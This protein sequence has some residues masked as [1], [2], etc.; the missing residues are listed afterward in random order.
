MTTEEIEELKKALGHNKSVWPKYLGQ[1]LVV[2][3]LSTGIIA[4]WSTNKAAVAQNVKDIA[5]QEKVIE[6]HSSEIEKVKLQAVE[7]SGDLKHLIKQ[8]EAFDKKL[9]RILERR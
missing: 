7:K 6:K 8:V 9:D 1:I 2:I 4:G 5:K 3:V